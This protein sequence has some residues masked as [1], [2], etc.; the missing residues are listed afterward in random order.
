M[1]VLRDRRSEFEAAGVATYAASRDSPYSHTAWRQTL[2]LDFP[3][4]SDWNAEAV[5]AFGVAQTFDGFADTPVRS[6][7]LI[8]SEGI[9]RGA[10]RYETTEVPDFDELLAAAHSL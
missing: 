7:F 2:D 3:L 10:W 1:G 5:R 4:L 9:I 6:A 8:G